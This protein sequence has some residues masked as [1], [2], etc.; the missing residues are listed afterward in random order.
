MVTEGSARGRLELSVVGD[1]EAVVERLVR[2]AAVA[3]PGVRVC[4]VGVLEQAQQVVVERAAARVV[5]VALGEALFDLGEARTDAVL[6]SFQ[7]G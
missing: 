7:G 1:V 2:Q 5:L 6:M 4:V 3:V